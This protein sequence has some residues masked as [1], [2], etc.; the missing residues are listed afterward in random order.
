MI[1]ALVFGFTLLSACS[2]ALAQ[3]PAAA[4]KHMLIGKWRVLWTLDGR[5]ARLVVDSVTPGAVVTSFSGT[6]EEASQSCPASGSVLDR[7]SMVYAEGIES[8]RIDVDA[9]VV[10]GVTCSDRVIKFEML[11]LP[12]GGITMSGRAF[13]KSP[14]G[15]M[16]VAPVAVGRES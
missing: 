1:R 6:F 2:L 15:A 4:P 3:T 7:T 14:D 8:T 13:L 9:L 11:G 10:I 5:T 12:A 16:T